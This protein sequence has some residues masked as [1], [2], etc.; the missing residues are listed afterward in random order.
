MRGL[1]EDV[2]LYPPIFAV[3]MRRPGASRLLECH[4][5]SCKTEED[6]V[7]AAATLYRVLLSDFEATRRRPRQKNGIGRMSIA[8][9]VSL[10]SVPTSIKRKPP[11]PIMIPPPP[12]MQPV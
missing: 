8:S 10:I 6:V 7:A 11:S 12:P 2:S 4:A 5:F 1:S 3:V 9:G